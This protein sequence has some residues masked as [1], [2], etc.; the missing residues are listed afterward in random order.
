MRHFDSVVWV[1]VVFWLLLSSSIPYR[2]AIVP[3]FHGAWSMVERQLSES[4]EG[5]S[6]GKA[7]CRCGQ[8]CGWLHLFPRCLASSVL[9]DPCHL[10]K[11]VHT[12][13]FRG[14]SMIHFTHIPHLIHSFPSFC[15]CC[16]C[17]GDTLSR[18]RR[19][20]SPSLSFEPKGSIPS[21]I[22]NAH[23]LTRLSHRFLLLVA[24]QKH[25]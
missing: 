24:L 25:G 11:V 23:E 4:P 19:T 17:K 21:N 22:P 15:C 13:P 3:K 1:V 7:C 2:Y 6:V 20:S 12:S 16:C 14:F 8:G 9:A 18:V 5:A 10:S